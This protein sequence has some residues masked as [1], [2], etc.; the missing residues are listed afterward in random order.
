MTGNT[1]L[2]ERNVCD[3]GKKPIDGIAVRRKRIT[4]SG[5]GRQNIMAFPQ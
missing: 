2:Q 4:G 5:A 1:C 3:W